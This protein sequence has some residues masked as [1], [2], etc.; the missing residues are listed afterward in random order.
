MGAAGKRGNWLCR[1]R[2]SCERYTLLVQSKGS[3]KCRESRPSPTPRHCIITVLYHWGSHRPQHTRPT[4]RENHLVHTANVNNRHVP[5]SR[6]HFHPTNPKDSL[7]IKTQSNLFCARGG[8][9]RV[10]NGA[11]NW[12]VPTRARTAARRWSSRTSQPC[13]QTRSRRPGSPLADRPGAARGSVRGVREPAR[14][15][16]GARTAKS[17]ARLSSLPPRPTARE[18]RSSTPGAGRAQGIGSSPVS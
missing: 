6:R 1:R 11:P 2:R 17:V 12:A 14:A 10:Y 18:S 9:S 8:H 16:R 3:A 7:G 13:S 4:Q 5:A 15:R